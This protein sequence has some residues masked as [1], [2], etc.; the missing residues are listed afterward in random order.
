ME[1]TPRVHEI[2]TYGK[3]KRELMLTENKSLEAIPFEI[4]A[5][6]H[7]YAAEP[8][9]PQLE[10]DGRRYTYSGGDT[11]PSPYRDIEDQ[12]WYRVKCDACGQIWTVPEVIMTIEYEDVMAAY[13]RKADRWW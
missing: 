2:S 10:T 4:I 1:A 9:Q 3:L 12:Y 5:L 7:E 13:K 6:I 11:Y 8:C